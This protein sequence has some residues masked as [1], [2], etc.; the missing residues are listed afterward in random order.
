MRPSEHLAEF[1]RSALETGRSPAEI[2]AAL[3]DAGWS[4]KEREDALRGWIRSDGLPPVPRP[5]PYVSARE[6]LIYGLVFISLGAVAVHLV[7]LGFLLTDMLLPEQ[8]QNLRYVRAGMRWPIAA[9]IAFTPVF[10]LLNRAIQRKSAADQGRRRSLVRK[11]V[12]S[13]TLLIATVSLLGDLVVTLFS[14]LNGEM[15]LRFAIKAVIVAVVAGL[16]FAYYRDELDEDTG[17]DAKANQRGLAVSAI[18]ACVAVAVVAGLIIGGGPIRARQENRDSE[19]YGDL[20]AINRHVECRI[21]EVGRIPDTLENSEICPADFPTNDPY[22]GDAYAF[23]Q[24]DDRHWR[25]CADFELPDQL[26]ETGYG[27]QFDAEAGCLIGEWTAEDTQDVQPIEQSDAV[28]S[29]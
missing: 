11:W 13:V 3:Q 1:V 10:L 26:A 19:R 25:V 28:P 16:V 23:S 7:V 15:T 22:T 8:G 4:E 18:L 20:M 6:A 2:D 12:A 5:R 9:L 29:N 14:L 21:S 27:T 24:I 17:P